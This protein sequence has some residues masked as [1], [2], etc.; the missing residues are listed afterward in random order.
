MIDG[1]QRQ[2]GM[3]KTYL[4]PMKDNFSKQADLYAQFRPTYP[5]AVFTH[6]MQYVNERNT[7]WD[8]ATGNGQAAKE[9][10]RYFDTV[11]ATDI[12]EK[13][14]QNAVHRDNI[15]Y[16]IESAENNSFNDDMFDLITV[17]QAIHWFDFT[18]FY[19]EVKRTSK[20]GGIL[21]VIGYGLVQTSSKL[22]DAILHFYQNTVGPY[23]DKE[24]KYIDENYQTIPFPFEE[25]EPIQLH[26]EYEWNLDRLIGYL[27]TWS[28]VQHYI[29]ANHSNPVDL[30]YND[31]KD[32]WDNEPVKLFYFPIFVRIGRIN[33]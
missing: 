17:A 19:N 26:S 22:N 16:K 6:V 2:C 27:N 18:R 4:L 25:L 14:I 15:I 5:G 3:N 10:A 11:Y 29:K 20:P 8:C 23:W 7:A 30:V 32:A 9:L 33:K 31:L 28:S 1:N 13:Q 24:R 12:S 21:A